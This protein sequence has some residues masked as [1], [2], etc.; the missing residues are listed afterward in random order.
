MRITAGSSWGE[1][2]Q[3][4]LTMHRTL[5]RPLL[6]YGAIALDSIRRRY[7]KIN[8]MLYK[9]MLYVLRAEQ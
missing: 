8:L 9:R 2:K 4:L 5:I 6:E 1:N 3:T 7:I